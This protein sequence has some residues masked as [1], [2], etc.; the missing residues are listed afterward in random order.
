MVFTDTNLTAQQRLSDPSRLSASSRP[1]AV[2]KRFNQPITQLSATSGPSSTNVFPNAI[3]MPT[4]TQTTQAVQTLSPTSATLA[5]MHQPE[6]RQ[7]HPNGAPSA[8]LSENF[9]SARQGM[10][11]AFMHNIAAVKA[12]YTSDMSK[13]APRFS[14]SL[15]ILA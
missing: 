9:I 2:E 12:A 15:S 8:I 13:E 4:P 10:S 11:P 1:S 3:T 7:Y 6:R 5:I 14:D